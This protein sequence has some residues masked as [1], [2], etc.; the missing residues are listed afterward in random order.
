M[1]FVYQASCFSKLGKFVI[2]EFIEK[3]D[4]QVQILLANREDIF[5]EYTKKDFEAAFDQ[6]FNTRHVTPIKDSRRTLYLFERK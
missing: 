2:V 4:S 3:D 6:Y 1:P 5:N